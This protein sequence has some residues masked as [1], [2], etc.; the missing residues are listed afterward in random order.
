MHQRILQNHVKWKQRGMPVPTK[1]HSKQR[2]SIILQPCSRWLLAVLRRLSFLEAHPTAG[3]FG[4]LGRLEAIAYVQESR[5]HPSLVR[6][7]A[8]D[9]ASFACAV[10]G[11]QLVTTKLTQHLSPTR[12]VAQLMLKSKPQLRFRKQI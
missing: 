8:A 12:M 1:Q 9:C 7:F 11:R 4:V 10:C 2:D 6:C 3:R 5:L